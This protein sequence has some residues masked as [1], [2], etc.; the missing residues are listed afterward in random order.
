MKLAQVGLITILTISGAF[1]DGDIAPAALVPVVETVAQSSDTT[2]NGEARAYYYTWEG[3]DLFD[4]ENSQLAASIILDVSHTLIEGI[5]ANFSAVGAVNFMDDAGYM[6]GSETEA[7]INIANITATFGDTTLVAGRQFLNTPMLLGSGWLLAR[8]SFEAYTLVNKSISNLTLIGS[9]IAKLRNNNSGDNFVDL[10]DIGDGNNWAVS[11]AYSDAFD[12]NIWYYNVDASE[13]TQIYIDTSKEFSGVKLEGQYIAT[14]YNT[15]PDSTAYGVKV[16]ASL[17]NV[18]LSVA[19]NKV[20]DA[21]AGHVGLDSL[22]ASSWNILAADIVDDSWKIAASTDFAGLDAELSYA[23]YGEEGSEL[24]L[25]LGYK[26]TDSFSVEAILSSTD[27]TYTVSD[28]A[29]NAFEF[30]AAYTF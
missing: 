2:I 9:Y 22:Y 6:E 23:I 20:E 13:Y 12:A 26:I 7:F 16:S 21:A 11:A 24:D 1:A 5:T 30:M 17:S 25:I 10:T 4:S 18:N 27:Y 14:D 19:Y 29:E 15:D 28:D 3:A 8:G